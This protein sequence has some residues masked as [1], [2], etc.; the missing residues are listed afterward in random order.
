[1]QRISGQLFTYLQS[2]QAYISPPIAAVFLLGIFSKRINSPGATASLSVGFVLGLMRLAAEM[3]KPG[4]DAGVWHTL[5]TVNFLLYAVFL[6]LVCATVLV[7]VS[8]LT[9]A[10]SAEQVRGLTYATSERVAAPRADLAWTAGLI[11]GVAATWLY[12]S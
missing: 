12:F 9:P 7:G 4:P 2:V 3:A 10:P 11:G 1:M 6:F 8:A 5:A